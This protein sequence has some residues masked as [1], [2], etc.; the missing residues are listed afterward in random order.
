[1]SPTAARLKVTST[2]IKIGIAYMP[3]QRPVHGE[4]AVQIQSALLEPRTAKP[5]PLL[6]RI[7][8]RVWKWL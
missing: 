7:F 1:M 3:Q 6:L 2:G 4:S 5:L 8:G